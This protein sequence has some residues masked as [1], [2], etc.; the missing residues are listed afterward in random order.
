MFA[1]VNQFVF[2]EALFFKF[3]LDNFF[4]YQNFLKEI[5]IILADED[6]IQYQ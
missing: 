4:S 1:K 3:S 6:S 5:W 2:I